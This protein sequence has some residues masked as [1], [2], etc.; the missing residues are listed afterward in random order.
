MDDKY[1][2]KMTERI[3]NLNNDKEKTYEFICALADAKAKIENKINVN[4]F[5]GTVES[6]IAYIA[7]ILNQK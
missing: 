2:N 5:K 3:L 7:N 1:I 6:Q 4:I